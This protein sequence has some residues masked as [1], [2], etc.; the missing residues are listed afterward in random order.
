MNDSKKSHNW[1]ESFFRWAYTERARMVRDLASGKEVSRD[2]VF[3]NFTRHTPVFISH[4]PAGL[5]G[6]VK[7]VGFLPREEYLEST[8]KAYLEHIE[9]GWDE[10]YSGRGLNL[11]TQHM[12]GEGCE[13]KV[14]FSV[15]GSLEMAFKHSWENFRHNDGVTLLFYQ[16]PMISFE[17][18]GRIRIDEGG[19][20][21]QF[22][23]AQHDV[24]HKP[25]PGA[26]DQRAAYIITI[27]EIFDNSATKEG[28]G[29]KI[30]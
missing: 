2:Q 10:G 16:P 13:K 1:P 15:L 18:R 27:Q 7:G 6:S 21:H 24:Y 22:I 3:L 5:N 4:G 14:D 20:Y 9:T 12:W 19:L 17:V 8:L 25:N 26:W 28:F 30:L 29:K 11:L 23:N